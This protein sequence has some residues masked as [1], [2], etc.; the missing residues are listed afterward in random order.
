MTPK[1]GDRVAPPPGPDQYDVRFDS[2]EAAKGW[3]DLC[4]QASGNTFD[5]WVAMRTK[6]CPNPPTSRHEPLKGLSRIRCFSPFW[7]SS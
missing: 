4:Q 6:P 1:R 7:A 3:G 2:S 5:A